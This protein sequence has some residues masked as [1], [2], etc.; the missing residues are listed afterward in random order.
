MLEAN[1][2]C[3]PGR[4]ERIRLKRVR[5]MFTVFATQ[6]TDGRTTVGRT[7]DYIDPPA[8]PIDKNGLYLL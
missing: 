2:A 3:K 6:R 8:T 1:G 4:Y 7:T 5:V